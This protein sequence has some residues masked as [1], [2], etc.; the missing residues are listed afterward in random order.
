MSVAFRLKI[1]VDDRK[2]AM[3]HTPHRTGTGPHGH[4]CLKRLNTREARKRAAMRDQ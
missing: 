4:K 3:G 1:K 2:V